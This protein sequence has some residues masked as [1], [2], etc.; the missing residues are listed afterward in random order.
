MRIYGPVMSNN[1]FRPVLIARHIGVALELAPVNLPGGEHKGE[2]FRQLNPFGRIPALEDEGLCLFESV[3]I[4]QY[5]AGK[6]PN[7]VWPDDNGIR[8]RIT[9]W[10]VWG[11]AHLARGVGPVQFNRMFR[12]IFNMGPPDEAAITAGL[13]VY[14]QEAGVLEGWLS[15]G[16]PWLLGADM[17]LADLDVAGWFLHADAA[18]LPMAPHTSAWTGRV[19]ALPAWSAALTS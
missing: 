1:V 13:A 8:A 12:A 6:Q 7:A 18:G 15:D 2:A 11:V 5:I 16:R 4:G 17:T 14:E 3:A 19:R 9:A 10:Q